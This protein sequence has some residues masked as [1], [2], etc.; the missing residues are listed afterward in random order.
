MAGH[1]LRRIFL[2]PFS[3][4]HCKTENDG[5]VAWVIEHEKLRCQNTACG[6]DIDLS[7]ADWF[8]FRNGLDQ[9]LASLQ[10]LY[11]KVPN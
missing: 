4:P 8:A 7:G 3:C 9:A 6:R 2:V 10:P 11:D 5:S 1:E